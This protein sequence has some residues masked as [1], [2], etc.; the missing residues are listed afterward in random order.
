MFVH[1]NAREGRVLAPD[2]KATI[3]PLDGDDDRDPIMVEVD[4]I[5]VCGAQA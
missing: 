2:G 1:Y 5:R 4:K 3:V